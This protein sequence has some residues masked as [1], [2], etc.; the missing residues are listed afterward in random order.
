MALTQRN[1]VFDYVD[2]EEVDIHRCKGYLMF[3]AKIPLGVTF[4]KNCLGH[5]SSALT[6]RPRLLAL[7][8]Q[9]LE[10]TLYTKI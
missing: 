1:L 5:E 4:M 3:F 10:I 6:T 2:R 8:T 9:G 7:V